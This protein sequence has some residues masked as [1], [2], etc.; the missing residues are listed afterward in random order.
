M[1]KKI[2]QQQI[3]DRLQLSRNTVSKALNNEPGLKEE[4]R[5]RIIKQAIEMGYTK[6]PPELL[7]TIQAH[8]LN[9]QSSLQSKSIDNPLIALLTHSDYVGNHYW[10]IFMKGLNTA[11]KE[12]GCTMAITLIDEE[13]ENQLQLPAL[14]SHQKPAGIVTIGAF[15]QAY[16]ERLE[17]TGIP[18]LFVD[19]YANF[20]MNKLHTD[21]LLVSNEESVY[22]LTT[23]LLEQGLK[24]IGFI[25]DIGSCLS[26]HERWSGY[27]KALRDWGIAI[28]PE[29]NIVNQL[30]RHY[31]RRPELEQ[32]L[33]EMKR[34]PQAFICA[35]DEIAV[36]MMQLL[37]AAGMRVPEDIILTG[38]DQ[39][40]ELAFLHSSI[41][42]VEVPKEEM[43]LRAGEQLLWRMAHPDRPK[44]LI[45]LGVKI[46]KHPPTHM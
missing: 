7:D 21:T 22:E 4:T 10:S 32:A 20:S 27:Q 14:F 6:F 9:E 13:E 18:A 5:D 34:L 8:H 3:A 38:F 43:G 44:E 29:I 31:Y 12:R 15:L 30:P 28:N 16:Y 25:G 35:N 24:E 45:R 40:G 2:T 41:P 19:T 17:Q 23:S 37:R 39:I 11:L 33:Q 46:H 42:T 1:T 26:Y 36:E